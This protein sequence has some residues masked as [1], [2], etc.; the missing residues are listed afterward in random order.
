MVLIEPL[1]KEESR[2]RRNT[3]YFIQRRDILVLEMKIEM[4]P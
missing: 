2:L 3:Y 4:G 1:T